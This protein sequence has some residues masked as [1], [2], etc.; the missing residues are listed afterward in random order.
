MYHRPAPSN[1]PLPEI[2][3]RPALD[4]GLEPALVEHLGGEFADLGRQPPAL[5]EEQPALG[6]DGL[7]RRE[8]VLERRDGRAL[9]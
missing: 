6:R 7:M 3:C 8:H 5:L 2:T 4:V 9:G 1:S